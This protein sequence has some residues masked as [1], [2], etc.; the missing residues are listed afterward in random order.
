M[1]L[2]VIDILPGKLRLIAFKKMLC[3]KK[4]KAPHKHRHTIA[5]TE[6]TE[7]YYIWWLNY[8]TFTAVVYKI[9]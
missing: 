9:S 4:V 3:R 6:N 7:K 2:K 5:E 8:N 1:T